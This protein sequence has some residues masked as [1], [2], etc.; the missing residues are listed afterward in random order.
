VTGGVDLHLGLCND[1]MQACAHTDEPLYV[2]TAAI[3]GS[4]GLVLDCCTL[5]QQVHVGLSSRVCMGI[6]TQRHLQP[7]QWGVGIIAVA[8]ALDLHVNGVWTKVGAYTHR[9]TPLTVEHGPCSSSSSNAHKQLFCIVS[10]TGCHSVHINRFNVACMPVSR[11]PE[12]APW[13]C[14]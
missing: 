5:G 13:S 4:A 3:L 7:S 10:S 6:T 14:P 9:L 1:A 12:F 8:T 11:W 2:H